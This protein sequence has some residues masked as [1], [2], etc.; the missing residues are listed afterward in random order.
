MAC[1]PAATAPCSWHQAGLWSCLRGLS[2]CELGLPPAGRSVLLVENMVY[3]T[4]VQCLGQLWFLQSTADLW[5][6]RDL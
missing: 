4:Q 3:Q 6:Q 1:W 5:G 2:S